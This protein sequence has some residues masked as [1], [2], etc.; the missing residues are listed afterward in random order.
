[1]SCW[2]R[3]TVLRIPASALGFT[4]RREWDEFLKKHENEFQWE[5]GFFNESLCDHYP[6]GPGWR[7]ADFY[8]PDRVLDQRNP[9]CPEIVPGPFLD[10]YLDEII[11]LSPEDNSYGENNAVYPLDE[12]EMEEYLPLYQRLFPHFTK[13]NMEAVRWCEYE[14]YDG[15]NALYLYS[16]WD[17]GD[18]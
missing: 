14:W 8:Q 4:F 6:Y 17:E 10:Y 13:K 2:R 11:P 5:P 1:M 18:E 15:T 9:A 12:S 16:E 3:T 7:D